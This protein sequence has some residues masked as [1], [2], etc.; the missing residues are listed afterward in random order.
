MKVSAPNWRSTE[1][2]RYA[3]TMPIKKPTSAVI[4]SACAPMRYR[5]PEKSRHGPR[6]GRAARRSRSS[7][8]WPISATKSCT[9]CT[10]LTT[11]RPSA[12]TRSLKVT[13]GA[14]GG[15]TLL[16]CATRSSTARWSSSASRRAGHWRCQWSHSS[17][18]PRWS[19]DW[20]GRRS[21]PPA[22]FCACSALETARSA[23]GCVS[24][25]AVQCPCS[26]ATTPSGVWSVA[27][28]GAASDMRGAGWKR[29][30]S[31]G[32]KAVRKGYGSARL[33]SKRSGAGAARVPFRLGLRPSL[34]P[35]ALPAARLGKTAMVA[36]RR[37]VHRRAH[38]AWLCR[39]T[40]H[41]A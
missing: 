36:P 15:G 5:W 18:A 17:R 2:I 1:L 32:E 40:A 24:C 9:C 19:S 39:R 38:R 16:N 12:P 28:L 8:S 31:V 35:P 10:P 20:M 7:A 11:A 33:A 34:E 27:M 14:S 41:V 6:S 4:G 23:A 25:A 29:A 26:T 3:S 22:P 13:G 37:P 21:Q 30:A